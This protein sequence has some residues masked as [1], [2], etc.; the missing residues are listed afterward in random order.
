MCET[1]S[2]QSCVSPDA[3]VALAAIHALSLVLF[4]FNTRPARRRMPAATSTSSGCAAASAASAAAAA[5]AEAAQLAAEN[6]MI[7]LEK[8][9][10]KGYLAIRV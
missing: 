2:T 8:R 10:Q 6:C 9:V 7:Y 3:L 5:H 1:V 4:A